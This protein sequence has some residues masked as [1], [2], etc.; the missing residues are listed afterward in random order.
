MNNSSSVQAI[1]LLAFAQAPLVIRDYIYLIR[2]TK[3]IPLPNWLS[4][5]LKLRPQLFPFLLLSI[6][7]HSWLG[8]F[9]PVKTSLASLP[10]GVFSQLL[11]LLLTL[12]L[13]PSFSSFP[14]R[15]EKGLLLSFISWSSIIL[16]TLHT[17]L[18]GWSTLATFSCLPSPQQIAL[19]PPCLTLGLQLPLVLPWIRR[20]LVDVRRGHVYRGIY[21]RK[22]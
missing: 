19:L 3:S 4:S 7:L 10:P 12:S 16:S 18:A 15:K 6:F 17:L 14:S 2:G 1:L 22:L 13:H 9:L 20:K 11:L 21:E 5:W 8:L